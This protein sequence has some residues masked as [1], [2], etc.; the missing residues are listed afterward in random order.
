MKTAL[1]VMTLL[2]CD[3][4]VQEC[5]YV[6]TVD[7]PWASVEACQADVTRQISNRADMAFPALTGFCTAAEPDDGLI[8]RADATSPALDSDTESSTEPGMLA[9]LV[10]LDSVSERVAAWTSGGFGYDA[11]R[12][13]LVRVLEGTASATR[14]TTQWLHIASLGD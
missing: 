1:V 11:V 2:G 13:R 3:C 5:E 10:N 6:Q 9:R 7:G 12:G 8:M 4:T 14:S